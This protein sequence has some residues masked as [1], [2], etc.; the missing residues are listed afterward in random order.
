MSVNPFPVFSRTPP[1]HTPSPRFPLILADGQGLIVDL[2]HHSYGTP[3]SP[4][5]SVS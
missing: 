3:T 4:S 2:V 5:V 1:L